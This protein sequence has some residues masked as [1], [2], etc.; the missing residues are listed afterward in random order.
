[1]TMTKQRPSGDSQQAQILPSRTPHTEPAYLAAVARYQTIVSEQSDVE[2]QIADLERSMVDEPAHGPSAAVRAIV[3]GTDTEP[4]GP[5]IRDQLRTLHQRSRDLEQAARILHDEIHGGPACTTG[6][7]LVS[8]INR[9]CL[10]AI[11]PE[12]RE[13]LENIF[14]NLIDL[15]DS[16]AAFVAFQE[17]YMRGGGTAEGIPLHLGDP[18][19]SNVLIHSWIADVRRAVNL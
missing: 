9:E 2:R 11:A 10:A 18:R 3:A 8:D 19:D 4:Q 5:S 6:R 7:P 15:R 14:G 12:R 16:L 17:A 13:L 1:M